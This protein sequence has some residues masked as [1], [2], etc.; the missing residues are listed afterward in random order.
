MHAAP[1]TG[2]DTKIEAKGYKNRARGKARAKPQGVMGSSWETEVYLLLAL[3]CSSIWETPLPFN[4]EARVS[5]SHCRATP[6]AAEGAEGGGAE[7]T[8][9][10]PPFPAKAAW[11]AKRCVP[12]CPAMP[13]SS[14]ERGLVPDAA[15]DSAGGLTRTHPLLRRK[16][17]RGIRLWGQQ[18][19]GLV[20]KHFLIARRN[21]AASLT[22]LFVPLFFLLV[23]YG[24]RIRA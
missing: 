17:V 15:L 6:L 16:R 20:Y 13:P 19:A 2:G 21:W 9:P 11:L 3:V 23:I 5:E 22:R 8:A 7:A 1:V 10:P 24:E 12:R 14:P 18:F 4:L